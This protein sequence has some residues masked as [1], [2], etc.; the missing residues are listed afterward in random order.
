MKKKQFPFAAH[1]LPRVNTRQYFKALHDLTAVT[2]S[3]WTE[4]T[5]DRYL[6]DWNLSVSP[7]D[8]KLVKLQPNSSAYSAVE[9]LALKTWQSQYVGHGQDAVGLNQLNYKNM[10]ITK[11][12]RMESPLLFE[13]YWNYREKILLRASQKGRQFK[14]LGQI[15]QAKNGEVRTS[16]IADKCLQVE[17]YPGINE[18]YLFHG[19]QEGFIENIFTQGLDG[20]IANNPFFGQGIYCAESSTKSDQ[21]AGKSFL[22]KHS[23]KNICWNVIPKFSNIHVDWNF[24]GVEERPYA[25]R[26]K[27]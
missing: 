23:S 9:K 2:P 18:H 12:E 19:T 17:I 8:Y 26:C 6:K 11:I 10:K 16:Q 22:V 1:P 27:T 3:Y 21:Y 13:G 5:S 14:S 20:R 24:S 4:Y 7:K 25:A 15:S